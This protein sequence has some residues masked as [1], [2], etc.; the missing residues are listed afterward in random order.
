MMNSRY[1]PVIIVTGISGIVTYCLLLWTT[2][3]LWAQT[4]QIFY[5]LYVAT[6]VAYFTYIYAKVDKE[7]FLKVTSHTR[8]AL[9]CGRFTS[10]VLAQTLYN[11]KLL[12]IRQL[13]FI[14]LGAQISATCWALFLPSVQ[15]SVYFYHYG[16]EDN[17]KIRS[18]ENSEANGTKRTVKHTSINFKAAFSLIFNQFRSA[19]SKQNVILWSIWYVIG[20]CGHYQV[21]NY[22]QMLWLSIDNNPDVRIDF[23]SLIS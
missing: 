23:L 6:E 14:T 18:T 11:T 4:I 22:I 20:M 19:Y 8:A 15:K 9:L 21:I 16:T 3:K 10:G 2:T 13:N 5:A 1:K 7:Y 12:D 17:N